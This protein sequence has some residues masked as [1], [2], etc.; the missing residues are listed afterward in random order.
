VD[1]TAKS[2]TDYS[3]VAGS[4]AVPAADATNPVVSIPVNIIGDRINE[5]NETFKLHVTDANGVANATNIGD[6]TFT[7][8]DD[9]NPPSWSTQDVSVVEGNTGQTMAHIPVNLTS[10]VG[11]DATFT[12]AISNGTAVDAGT[13]AGDNDFDAPTTLSTTIKAGESRGWLDIPIN[14]DAVFEKDEAFTVTFTPPSNIDNSSLDIVPTSRVVITNDDAA[15]KLTFP[16]FSGPEGGTVS[17]TGTIVGAA[18]APYTI[19][20][21]AQ[22]SGTAPATAGTDFTVP[23][24][25]ATT[26]YTIPRGFTGAL[27]DVPASAPNPA[28]LATSVQ[29]PL[30]NDN[31]DEATET[32]TVTATETTSTLVGFMNSSGTVK[33]A[34]DPLDMPPAVSLGD[35]SVGEWEKS[36]DIPV[37]LSF[38][39]DNDATSTQQTVTI[40]YWTVDGS[41]KAGAD[42]KE[43][44]G[45]LEIK[46]GDLTGTINVPVIDDKSQE[47]REDFY[48]KTG[49]VGPAGTTVTNSA[50]NVIIKDND[51]GGSTPG[52]PTIKAPTTVVGAVAVSITGVAGSGDKVELW[53]APVGGGNLAYITSTTAG[54]SGSYSFSRWIGQGYRFATQTGGMNSATVTVKVTQNPLFTLTSGSKG[55]V[56][57]AVQGNPKAAKQSVVIQRLVGGKWVNTTW[58]GTTASDNNQ[59]KAT[60]SE[61]SKSKWTL[62]AWVAGNTAMGINSGYSAAKSVTVK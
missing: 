8:D 41:A 13:L 24:A 20:F 62:R 14:G 26:S 50:A 29:F 49:S 37:D 39:A 44:K 21:S 36:V 47:A 27:T 56:S 5:A 57:L 34:D 1:G 55:K 10:P 15:P 54:A 43:T 53:G 59:W 48:V 38:T 4:I 6:V 22:G 12:A 18:Q 58:K 9:D 40:P 61:P 33:I 17:I 11:S 16:S 23:A 35:V 28:F 25:L 31:V 19:G 51:E 32:F 45:T 46:P 52:A 60:V 7:I 30:L 3:G 2:G 42:Y